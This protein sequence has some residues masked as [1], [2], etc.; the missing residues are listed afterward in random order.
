MIELKIYTAFILHGRGYTYGLLQGLKK[1]ANYPISGGRRHVRG[2]TARSME[3][4]RF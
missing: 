3:D 2:A 4:V 1:T